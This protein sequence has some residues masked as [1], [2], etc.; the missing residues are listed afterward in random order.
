MFLRS[1]VVVAA[2]LALAACEGE[3]V[4]V[5][6]LSVQVM[7]VSPAGPLQLAVG[8]TVALEALPRIG[9]GSVH[10]SLEIE[11][12]ED[13]EV[14]ELAEVRRF[15]YNVVLRAVAPGTS[16]VSATAE[17]KTGTVLVTVVEAE[18]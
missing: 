8:Q 1:C 17:G 15:G 14:V 4:E 2:A 18:G 12:T 16:V 6:D 7:E 11:W 9:D 5:P 10:G 3:L 13:P